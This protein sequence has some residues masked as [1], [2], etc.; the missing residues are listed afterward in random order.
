MS[1]KIL[2]VGDGQLLKIFPS[3]LL[4]GDTKEY[5]RDPVTDS[6]TAGDLRV[7]A[8]HLRISAFLGIAEVGGVH[9]FIPCNL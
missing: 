3:I 7:A 4:L 9:V 2:I 5:L 8:R 6:R 1:I